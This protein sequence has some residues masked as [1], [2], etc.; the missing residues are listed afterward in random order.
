[1]PP[2]I[3][4][5]FLTKRLAKTVLST[6]NVSSNSISNLFDYL[7]VKMSKIKS[8]GNI[9]IHTMIE[10]L[11]NAIVIVIRIL[12]MNELFTINYSI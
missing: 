5:S 11:N 12:K 9:I 2:I 10:K 8:M 1:L 6:L 4:D 3:G 7:Y